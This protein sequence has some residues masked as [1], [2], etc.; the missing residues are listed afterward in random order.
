MSAV[1][2]FENCT[3]SDDFC[4]NTFEW[5]REGYMPQRDELRNVAY[6]DHGQETTG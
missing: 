4:A 3:D 6:T 5:C 2:I 1:F